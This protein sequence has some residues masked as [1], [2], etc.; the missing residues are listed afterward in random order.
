ME[1][2]VFKNQVTKLKNILMLMKAFNIY[3]KSKAI[4]EKIICKARA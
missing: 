4:S 3:Y 1:I 2:I